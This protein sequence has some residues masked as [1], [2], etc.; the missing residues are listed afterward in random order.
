MA[1]II[2]NSDNDLSPEDLIK[3][4]FG[5]EEVKHEGTVWN[6]SIK[7]KYYSSNVKILQRKLEEKV[8]S[9]SNIGASIWYSTEFKHSDVDFLKSWQEELSSISEPKEADPEVQLIIVDHFDTEDTK[10]AVNKWSIQNSVELIDYSEDEN[11]ETSTENVAIFASS[12]QKRVVES[13]QT[14]MWPQLCDSSSNDEEQEKD[15]NPKEKDL[16]DFESLFANLV[17]FKETA[18]GL[19][20]QDRR[21]FAEKVAMSFFNALGDEGEDSD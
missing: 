13:L 21:K 4:L 8:V 11:E 19:P 2:W 3:K 18:S 14:V 6:W 12:A 1:C 17:H 9:V 10:T 15:Q 20:D 5:S 16:E 7:N